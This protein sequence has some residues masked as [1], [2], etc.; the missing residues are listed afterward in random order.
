MDI[1]IREELF[2]QENF[3]LDAFEALM[4]DEL[5][6]KPQTI[7]NIMA[8]S[9]ALSVSTFDSLGQQETILN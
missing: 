8:Y 6:P 9:R 7:S 3:N 1:T 4:M 5:K 2:G